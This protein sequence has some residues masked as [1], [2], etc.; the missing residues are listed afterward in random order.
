MAF[1]SITKEIN[2]V[3]VKTQEYVENLAEYYKL[4]LF[5]SAMK[6]SVALVNLLVTGFVMLFIL[7][8]VSIGIS[9]L[10]NEALDSRYWG[11]FIVAGFYILVLIILLNFGKNWIESTMLIKF[12]DLFFDDD[13]DDP[14]NEAKRSAEEYTQKIS[15]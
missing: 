9:L 14:E 4:R 7:L 6:G 12:S 1:G 2:K 10:L 3:G 11:Y 8:F 15:E 13:D 5:K